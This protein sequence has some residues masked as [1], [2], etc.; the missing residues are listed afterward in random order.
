MSP[1]MTNTSFVGR[2]FPLECYSSSMLWVKDGTYVL[3]GRSSKS[4]PARKGV[5]TLVVSP[6]K[7][8]TKCDRAS[9][10]LRE[11][12]SLSSDLRF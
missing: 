10:R 8:L 6:S 11:S 3:V 4:R 2:A 7:T 9:V 5:R 1:F 12:I